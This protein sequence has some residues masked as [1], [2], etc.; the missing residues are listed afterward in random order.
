MPDK[1]LLLDFMESGWNQQGCQDY[2]DG[3]DGSFEELRLLTMQCLRTV[4]QVVW[5][6]DAIVGGVAC[7]AYPN[8]HCQAFMPVASNK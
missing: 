1:L 4:V 6:V 8:V 3:N 5:N 7:I 2:E